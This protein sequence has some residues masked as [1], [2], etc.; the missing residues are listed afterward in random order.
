MSLGSP[1]VISIDE[2]RIFVLDTFI[3][4][5]N[6]E[7]ATTSTAI[8]FGC[9]SGARLGL[10]GALRHCLV[11]GVDAHGESLRLAKVSGYHETF[12]SEILPF[13]SR[14][15]SDS[16][17]AA[18]AI[19]VVEHFNEEDG[20]VLLAQMIRVAKFRV[21]VMTPTGFLH[22]PAAPDNPFQEHRSGWF[23]RQ[24][25]LLG[26]DRIYGVYGHR[27]LRGEFGTPRLRP[28][29][30]GLRLSQLTE[31]LVLHRPNAAF[32]FVAVKD[33]QPN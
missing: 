6:K 18:I 15:A 22:Q 31:R 33:I 5:L 28:L 19:D 11:D 21:I 32:A 8:D 3:S 4:I 12:R 27:L 23:P 30:V 2:A 26:F 7:L 29:R 9:G 17:E 16:Y 10:S 1:R 20:R 13:A 25:E 14:L 24:F